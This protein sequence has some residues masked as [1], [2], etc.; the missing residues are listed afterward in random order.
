MGKELAMTLRV[1]LRTAA[2]GSLEYTAA[3]TVTV[4]PDG[5][6]ELHDPEGLVPTDLHVLAADEDGRIRK[7]RLE[8]DPATWARNL[9]SL[10][11]TG[12]LVPVIVQDD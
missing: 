8:D 5:S 12:Y 3:A 1:E 9:G 4:G 2:H 11:R 10:L 6:V 7:V